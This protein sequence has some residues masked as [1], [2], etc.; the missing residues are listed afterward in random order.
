MDYSI[1]TLVFLGSLLLVFLQ[2]WLAYRDSFLTLTQMRRA[3][4]YEGIPFL[5]H[6]GMWGDALIVGPLLGVLIAIHG[7]EW[8]DWWI[9]AFA[10]TAASSVMH[11]T[12]TL[13]R[14]HEAHIR[15]ERPTLVQRERLTPANRGRL[16]PAGWV[17][18]LYMSVGIAVFVQYYIFTPHPAPSML[19]TSSVLL[20]IHVVIGTHIPLG[21][22]APAW[23]PERPHR[24]PETWIVVLGTAFLLA[25]L[26]LWRINS[27]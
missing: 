25:V 15:R 8:G 3:H 19:I 6:G 14:L 17:H 26:T 2:G 27:L 23:Y 11:A 16:S 9:A 24:K 22:I 4:A 13:G 1:W 10:G 12:Y 21:L 20:V 5:A 18:W 7:K